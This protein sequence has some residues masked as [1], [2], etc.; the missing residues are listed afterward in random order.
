[1]KYHKLFSGCSGI[2]HTTENLH[3]TPK[4]TIVDFLDGKKYMSYTRSIMILLSKAGKGSTAW[5]ESSSQATSTPTK[6]DKLVIPYHSFRQRGSN[7]TSLV[8]T[9]LI[10]KTVSLKEHSKEKIIIMNLSSKLPKHCEHHKT[11]PLAAGCCPPEGRL[12]V[13][14]MKLLYLD[15]MK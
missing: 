5:R 6:G 14:T 4:Y 7:F 11:A 1:M 13:E 8:R 3:F 15:T 2:L 10:F 12:M 9:L